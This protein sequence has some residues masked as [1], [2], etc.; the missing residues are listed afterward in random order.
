MKILSDPSPSL[1]DFEPSPDR[2]FDELFLGLS[3]NPKSIPSKFLYDK[4]GC[5]LFDQICCLHEYYPTRTEMLILRDSAAEIG[6]LLGPGC[7]LIELGSGSSAKTRVLLDHLYEPAAYVPIDIARDHLLQ[8]AARLARIY[9]E[10]CI[11]P[12][13]ADFTSTLTLPEPPYSTQRTVAFFPGSTIGNLQPTEAE[14]FLRTR[15]SRKTIWL[16]SMMIFI[17]FRNIKQCFSTGSIWTFVQWPRY[18]NSRTDS[19]Y[20]GWLV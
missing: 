12:I 14:K 2:F 13:C 15:E 19:I 5:E 20:R 8:S 1:H 16:C 7:R 9:P 4:T 6:A 11:T 10:L 3:R 18:K 17:F